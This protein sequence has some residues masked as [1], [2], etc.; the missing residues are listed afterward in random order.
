MYHTCRT[1]TF[2]DWLWEWKESSLKATWISDTGG[3]AKVTTNSAVQVYQWLRDVCSTMLQQHPIKIGGPG[4]KVQIDESLYRHKPKRHRGEAT[5]NEVWVFGLVD[6]SYSPALGYMEIAPRRDAA[7]LLPIIQARMLPGTIIHSDEW[8]AHRRVAS[9]PN[10][11]SHDTVNHSVEFVNSTT[12]THTQSIE[13][14]WNRSKIKFKRM[15]G[16]HTS[17]LPS[18]LDE[19]MWWECSLRFVGHAKACFCPIFDQSKGSLLYRS[20]LLTKPTPLCPSFSGLSYIK[21]EEGSSRM[22]SQR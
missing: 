1:Q 10:V 18:Y 15:K 17:V 4:A 12:G 14:Y 19:F 7:T 9:L 16:C 22:T 6:T 11:S 2:R 21:T 13:S 8:A 5:Q 3:E 20:F